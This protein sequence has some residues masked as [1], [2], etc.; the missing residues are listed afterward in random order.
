MEEKREEWS[1][2]GS[3]ILST[4]LLAVGGVAGAV[5]ILF[6]LWGALDNPAEAASIALVAAATPIAL[7]GIALAAVGGIIRY[8]CS[9]WCD[10]DDEHE[11][12]VKLQP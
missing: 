10:W 7:G 1:G 9:D 11:H 5:A 12:P 3:W 4:V 2:G 8:C 6:A